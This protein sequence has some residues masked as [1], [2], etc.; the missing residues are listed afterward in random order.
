VENHGELRHCHAQLAGRCSHVAEPGADS[1]KA[2]SALARER[3]STWW[4]GNIQCLVVESY[5][6]ES[7]Y[8]VPYHD[9]KKY[10][11]M[12]N[13]VYK[14]RLIIYVII[15]NYMYIYLRTTGRGTKTGWNSAP[16][17]MSGLKTHVRAA[18]FVPELV[19]GHTR[20]VMSTLD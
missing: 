1:I 6:Q 3:K 5:S 4:N 18:R 10:Y 14:Y 16:H 12:V 20:S 15:C 2:S 11:Y 9:I 13:I 19:P 17:Q 8:Q 7:K